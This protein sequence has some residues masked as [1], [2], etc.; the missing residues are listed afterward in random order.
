MA[1]TPNATELNVL[2]NDGLYNI[3]S[4]RSKLDIGKVHD[5]IST[6]CY[7]AIGRPFDIVKSSIEH[8]FPFGVYTS[9]SEQIGF[10]RVVT[11]YRNCWSRWS[12][13]CIDTFAWVDDIYVSRP[14]RGKGISHFIIDTINE[15]LTSKLKIKHIVLFTH[16]AQSL[17][18]KHGYRVFSELDRQRWMLLPTK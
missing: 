5:W 16:D 10:A 4:D 1:P 8:S 3:S 9:Q 18:E 6:D 12:T 14:H 15:L 11:D 7:W 13:H 17:Y 2:R